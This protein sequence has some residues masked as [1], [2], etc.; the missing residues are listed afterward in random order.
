MGTPAGRFSDMTS[1]TTLLERLSRSMTI[2]LVAHDVGVMYRHVKT[3][4]CLNRRLHYHG[5]SEL[6]QETWPD[7]WDM[8][9]SATANLLVDSILAGHERVTNAVSRDQ[10]VGPPK[11]LQW[12]SGV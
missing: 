11:A 8:K 2:V 1:A 12:R 10:L 9:R 4:A 6:T 7:H 3:V 5:S